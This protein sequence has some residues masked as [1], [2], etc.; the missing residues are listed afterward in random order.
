[1]A[2]PVVIKEIPAQG[3]N[4]RAA[5]GPFDLTEYIQSPDGDD[6]RFHAEIST[7]A[8]LPKG[9]IC[10]EDG[11]VTGI[12]AKGT[13]GYYDIVVYATNDE[14]TAQSHFVLTIQPT[15]PDKNSHTYM[16]DLKQQ[17]WQALDQSLPPPDFKELL[18]HA[19]TPADVYY[20]WERWGT[21]TVYDAY[22]LDPPGE[23]HLLELDGVSEHY[24]VYDRGCCLVATPKDLFSH[25]RTLADGIRT[26]EA[27][28]REVYKRNWSVELTGFEKLTRAAW[29]EIQHMGDVHNNRLDVINYHPS[30]QDLSLYGRLADV[31]ILQNRME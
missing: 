23:K 4:E 29:V 15:I 31:R 6:L 30:K 28:A 3:V 1:M 14:G 10:T 8:C 18:E 19:I 17:I 25:E 20:L 2:A 22:N 13:E 27:V 5:Y 9:M 7:G 26:A 21:L 24:N 16:D 11:L 12:P